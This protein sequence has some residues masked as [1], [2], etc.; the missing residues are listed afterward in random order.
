[1]ANS[2]ENSP[3][4]ENSGAQNISPMGE[5]SEPINSL[6]LLFKTISSSRSSSRLLSLLF[7][8]TG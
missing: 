5:N 3:I 6:L 8:R 4:G 1:M 2:K 7:A